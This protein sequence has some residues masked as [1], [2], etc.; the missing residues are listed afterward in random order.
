MTR[1]LA[2]PGLAALGAAALAASLALAGAPAP[3]AQA[4][5]Q[6][7][8]ISH[9][10]AASQRGELHKVYYS[11]AWGYNTGSNNNHWQDTPLSAD[12]WFEIAF[13]GEAVAL[14]GNQRS[15]NGQGAVYL[16]DAAAGT[17]NCYNS[18]TRNGVVLFSV[19]GL[20]PGEHVVRVV[21]EYDAAGETYDYLNFTG[22]TVTQTVADPEPPDALEELQ[23]AYD[24]A[25]A[26][27][28]ADYTAGSWAALEAALEDAAAVLADQAASE[29]DLAGALAGL[30]QAE[31]LLVVVRG[32][33]ELVQL[34]Q[35]R[36]PGDHTAGS[37]P[38]FAAARLQAAGVLEDSEASAEAVVAA[39]NALL[40]AAGQLVTAQAG[41]LQTIQN[42]AW[43]HDTDGNP[44]FSQGGGI[45][46]FGDTY[47]WY[48][49]RYAG[50]LS[51]YNSPTKAYT[52]ADGS[53]SHLVAVTCYSSQDLVNWK[54]E[55][56]IV[57]AQTKV[58]VDPAQDT[59]AGYFTQ[60]KTVDDASW[61]GRMGVVYN[62]NTG[63]FVLITQFESKF[64]PDNSTNHSVAFFAGDSPT[65]DFEFASIQ[66]QIE[67]HTLTGT[68]DQTVFTDDD[69]ASYLISSN[70]SG[71]GNAY[72]SRISPAD[73]LSIERAVRVSTSSGREA[74]CMFKAEGVYYMATSELYGW[75]ASH[76][77][78]IKSLTGAIQGSYSSEWTMAGTERDFSHT[79]QTGFFFTVKGTEQDL[80]VF[81]GDR[82]ADFAWN[83]TGYNQWLPVTIE[84]GAPVAHSLSQWR[85]NAA[86]GAWEV[87]PGNNYLLNAD[88]QA[89]R[90]AVSEITGW[91]KVVDA[92][93]DASFVTNNTAGAG[94][95]RFAARL[96]R[97]GAFS[98]SIYQQA[99]APDGV[100]TLSAH[101]TR[102]AGLAQGRI[103]VTGGAGED[104]ALDLAA[105]GTSWNQFSLEGLKLTGGSAKVSVEAVN[106]SGNNNLTVDQLS[107][108]RTGPVP[109]VAQPLK[110]EPVV[111]SRCIAGKA[112]LVVTVLNSDEGPAEVGIE[113]GFGAKE[114]ASVQVGKYGAH[115][116][117][118]RLGALPAGLVVVKGRGLGAA[119]SPE[120]E[121]EAPYPAMTCQ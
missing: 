45:F 80:I 24:A 107:L 15:S 87:G 83:G 86:T 120:V 41:S 76:T 93:S 38:D 89:D 23:A 49:A 85:L 101:A 118:T 44:I 39:K 55:N 47:Y 75:N 67:N 91:T 59:S 116:F 60:M 35:T 7:L 71:R 88:F 31:S 78:L 2:R 82:W 28:Q 9:L 77:W 94:S 119:G 65:G 64:A 112:Y 40:A 96:T 70:Q 110:L 32:L 81:A 56:N 74:N 98:G 99:A 21:P 34:Y 63:R 53:D 6:T 61:V 73:S 33:R 84:D 115:A 20:E 113:T 14:S 4:A 102:S 79:T 16:D 108:V 95:S 25:A 37:W 57:T 97:N 121:L 52:A 100:Y 92:G 43:W 51:Y 29:Q 30:A 27:P 46:R 90:T 1:R 26:L 42:D 3:A 114:F 5:T 72:V 66:R 69:G 8:A 12:Q 18:S 10:D 117:T 36:A 19:E 11:G 106:T 48:G 58:E 50:A 111:S 104:Y 13:V 105:A 62:Q 109:Q 17:F 103:R 54:F 22:A 68:G